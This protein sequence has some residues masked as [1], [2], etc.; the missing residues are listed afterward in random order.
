MPQLEVSMTTQQVYSVLQWLEA[1]NDNDAHSATVST[2]MH[3]QHS[4]KIFTKRFLAEITK[5]Y[6]DEG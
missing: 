5:L 6:R 3:G 4:A 2:D 1:N